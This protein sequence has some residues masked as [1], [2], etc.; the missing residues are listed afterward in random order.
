[1]INFKLPRKEFLVFA[2]TD[3]SQ[4]LILNDDCFV[5]ETTYQTLLHEMRGTAVLTSN[6]LP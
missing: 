3:K 1:M 2:L 5:T 4:R 6:S